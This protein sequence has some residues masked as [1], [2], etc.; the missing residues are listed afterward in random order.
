MDW[1]KEKRKTDE[2]DFEAEELEPDN[3]ILTMEDM[4]GSQALTGN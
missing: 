1:L 3:E 2:S 4:Y